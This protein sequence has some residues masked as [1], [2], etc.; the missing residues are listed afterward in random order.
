M[1]GVCGDVQDRVLQEEKALLEMDS[2]THDKYVE[3]P[4]AS[5]HCTWL[6]PSQSIDNDTYHMLLSPVHSTDAWSGQRGI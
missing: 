5:P 3:H 4:T 1:F 2:N 6:I